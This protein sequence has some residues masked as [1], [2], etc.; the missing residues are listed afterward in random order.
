[1]PSPGISLS[2]LALAAVVSR[3]FMIISKVCEP[4]VECRRGIKAGDENRK[5]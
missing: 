1:M 5:R 4:V 3:L 2:S